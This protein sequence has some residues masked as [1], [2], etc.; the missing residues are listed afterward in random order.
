[1]RGDTAVFLVSRNNSATS[2]GGGIYNYAGTFTINNSIIA[3]STNG[4][5]C[6]AVWLLQFY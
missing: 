1:M 4:G 6:V 5:Y 3:N 2:N